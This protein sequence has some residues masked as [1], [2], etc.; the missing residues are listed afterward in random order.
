[1]SKVL[2]L[3]NISGMVKVIDLKFEQVKYMGLHVN[4]RDYSRTIATMVVEIRT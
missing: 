4:G 2:R 1:L 3:V